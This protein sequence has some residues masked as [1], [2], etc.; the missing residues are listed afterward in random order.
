MAELSSAL[1]SALCNDNSKGSVFFK[2]VICFILKLANEDASALLNPCSEQA[3]IWRA[4]AASQLIYLL[5]QE[6]EHLFLFC[7]EEQAQEK[8]M[9]RRECTARD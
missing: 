6:P 8:F 5:C 4:C 9:C 7:D 1:E 2:Q 3:D